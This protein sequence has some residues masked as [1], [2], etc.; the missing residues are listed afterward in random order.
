MIKID[1]NIPLP[2]QGPSNST[3]YPWAK[4]KPGDSF[5]VPDM[6]THRFGGTVGFARKNTGFKLVTRK[7]N[8]GVRVWRVS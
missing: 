7:S 2:F 8:N 6:T 4:L 3:K 5:F 1:K